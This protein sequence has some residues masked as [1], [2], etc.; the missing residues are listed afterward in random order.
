M[1]ERMTFDI[2]PFRELYPFE[3]KFF[4][5]RGMKMHYIDEGQGSPVVC[6]HGN[7]S[8]SFYYREVVKA[9]RETNRC[10]V[11]DHI[12]CGLSDKP[13]DDTY[14][15][16]Y[17]SRVD[18]LEALLEELDVKKDITLVVHDW[19]GAIG[20]GYAVRHPE[21]IKRIVL[22]N[23]AAFFK[24]EGKTMPWQ[25][26]LAR[27]TPLG[28]LL[29]RGFNAFAYGATKNC[30]VRKPMAPLVQLAFRAPYN[31][32]HNRIAT[33]RFVQDIPLEPEDPS[34]GP[35]EET[36]AGL[37]NFKETPTLVCWG[38][39]DYVFDHHFLKQWKVYLPNAEYHTFADVGHYT[40]ED[41]SEEVIALMKEFFEKHPIEEAS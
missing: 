28:S 33:L 4:Q 11:P 16:R 21:R 22:L 7:P 13:G 20:L 2:T 8:W 5:T 1:A 6:V 31:S 30:V 27:N 3:S 14:D 29:V 26:W 41:A 35:I 37:V 15:F 34:Y 17:K 39:K 19:G 18:D 32:W 23:T 9:F 38:E 24:P 25:L 12:G 36:V 10:I 40:L